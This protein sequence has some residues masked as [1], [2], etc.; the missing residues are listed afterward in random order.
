MCKRNGESVDHLFL[1]CSVAMDMWSMV[2][3]M[4]G[5]Q[6]VMPRSVLDLLLLDGEV[7]AE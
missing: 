2:L 3:G 4:F 6:L 7:E 1:H 5:V